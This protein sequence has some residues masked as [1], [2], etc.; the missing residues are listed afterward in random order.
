MYAL[1]TP[2][3]VFQQ[4]VFLRFFFGRSIVEAFRC[5]CN[6]PIKFLDLVTLTFD[7]DLQT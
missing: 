7:L 6:T 2:D 3:I 5:Q 4:M 1:K